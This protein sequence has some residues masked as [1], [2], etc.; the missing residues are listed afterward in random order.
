MGHIL[1]MHFI[2]EINTFFLA[3]LKLISNFFLFK[4]CDY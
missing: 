1:I 4:P 3:M 2:F